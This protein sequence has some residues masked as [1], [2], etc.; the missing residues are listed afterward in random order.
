LIEDADFIR[1]LEEKEWNGY[2]SPICQLS[3][4]SS[5]LTVGLARKLIRRV[6]D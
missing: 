4:S 5:K 1:L 3:S 2:L 6:N